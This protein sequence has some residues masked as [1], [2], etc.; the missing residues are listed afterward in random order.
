MEDKINELWFEWFYTKWAEYCPGDMIE[1]GV[2]PSKIAEQ[3]VN[4][5]QKSLL[6]IAKKFDDTNYELLNDFM[7]LS[8]SELHVLKYF[9]KLIKF[10]ASKE[11]C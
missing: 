2:K 5:N 4:E 7:S 8:E 1:K 10:N 3:F 9:L 6:N 11:S